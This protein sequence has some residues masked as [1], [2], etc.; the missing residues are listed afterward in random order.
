MWPLDQRM[1]MRSAVDWR[2]KKA[3]RASA[4]W[5]DAQD[6]IFRYRVSPAAGFEYVSPAAGHI[7]GYALDEFYADPELE[8]RLVTQMDRAS[9][10]P[11]CVLP[12][13]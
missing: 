12:L 1:W 9:L 11:S 13:C 6:M 2:S 5:R 10:S 3:R 4:A 7:T 8:L